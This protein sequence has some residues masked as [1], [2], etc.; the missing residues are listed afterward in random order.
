MPSDTP[1]Y[2]PPFQNLRDI[3]K[4]HLTEP[5]IFDTPDPYRPYSNTDLPFS[6]IAASAHYFSLLFNDI[7]YDKIIKSTNVYA[8]IKIRELEQQNPG[9]SSRLWIPITK[10]ELQVWI[11]VVLYI[12]FLGTNQPTSCWNNSTRVSQVANNMS[13]RRYEAIRR[14]IHTNCY[15]SA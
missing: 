12:A 10:P 9:S 2:K 13:L 14:Y 11:G 6:K 15:D 1:I 4:V 7:V 5:I 3:P 8:A